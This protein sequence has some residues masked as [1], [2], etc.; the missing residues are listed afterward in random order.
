MVLIAGIPR[1]RRLWSLG[2]PRRRSSQV[3]VFIA[4]VFCAFLLSL[5]LDASLFPSVP[6]G[7]LEPCA[8][9]ESADCYHALYPRHLPHISPHKSDD[10]DGGIKPVFNPRLRYVITPGGAAP[11]KLGRDLFNAWWGHF[12]IRASRFLDQTGLTWRWRYSRDAHDRTLSRHQCR[13]SLP[14]LFDELLRAKQQHEKYHINLDDIEAIRVTDGRTRVAISDGQLHVID[15]NLSTEEFRLAALAT[16]QSIQQAISGVPQ[17]VIPNIEFVIDVRGQVADITKPVWVVD[18][19]KDD[20][21]VWLT[22]F[23]GSLEVSSL[24]LSGQPPKRDTSQA[25]FTFKPLGQIAAEIN[26]QE[27][28]IQPWKKSRR[29]EM[30]SA[31]T[32]NEWDS[33]SLTN[34]PRRD[35]SAPD[36]CRHRVLI[37]P[38]SQS[39][40]NRLDSLLCAS[41]NVLPSPKWVHLY[42]GLMYSKP[43]NNGSRDSGAEFQNVALVEKAGPDLEK[44]TP[45]FLR[46]TKIAK[47]IASN[48]VETFRHRYLTEAAAACYWRELIHT[49][50]E[51]SYSPKVYNETDPRRGIPLKEFLKSNGVP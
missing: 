8:G 17:T 28:H 9:R 46:N 31:S 49:Y 33:F 36:V 13:K 19:R 2:V 44:G 24:N 35:L 6:W 45:D 4:L 39:T 14:G 37:H 7:L 38:D 26:H 41:V 3:S 20:D 50:R 16:L 27:S 25:N 5:S 12:W 32:T 22:P 42:H 11:N 51:V 29:E 18:R 21:K 34:N 40:F 10:D 43:L 1:L 47:T 30:K 23:I 15:S 48:T